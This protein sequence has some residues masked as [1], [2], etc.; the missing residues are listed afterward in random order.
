MSS[1]SSLLLA[2]GIQLSRDH[3][4]R[5]NDQLDRLGGE[6]Q[7]DSGKLQEIQQ[8][9]ILSH[10]EEVDSR[11]RAVLDCEQ[12]PV[13]PSQS[14]ISSI[15]RRLDASN[16]TLMHLDDSSDQ[17]QLT[18]KA[19]LDIVEGLE[20]QQINT[21]NLLKK[22]E[23]L[24][25]RGSVPGHLQKAPLI[26]EDALLRKF[27][28][29]LEFIS[30]Y[31]MFLYVIRDQFKGTEGECKIWKRDFGFEDK[32]QKSL[33]LSGV[34]SSDIL[35]GK[36]VF[37]R[38]TFHN[39]GVARRCCLGS[40]TVNVGTCDQAEIRCLACGMRYLERPVSSEEPTVNKA[41]FKNFSRPFL[42]S[43]LDSSRSGQ[44]VCCLSFFKRIEIR[45]RTPN[46]SANEKL[47]LPF[48]IPY[49][50]HSRGS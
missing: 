26:Y 50:I 23:A 38:V 10:E 45:S 17:S 33:E 4:Q 48:P 42:T 13:A 27:A 15:I 16:T 3:F 7:Q 6:L 34:W 47:L 14:S 41:V 46:E 5:I 29:D 44:S 12:P 49:G 18:L 19:L 9:Q 31:D 11:E 22:I 43:S 21:G 35:S 24:L 28:I 39:E 30:S 1:I 8:S 25:L 2:S 32:N 20:R 36:T 40:K 37:M